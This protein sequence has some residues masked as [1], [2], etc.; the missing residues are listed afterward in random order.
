ML[1]VSP[2]SQPSKKELA[3]Q[4]YAKFHSLD[5]PTLIKTFQQEL[6]V[7]ENCARTYIS[8]AAKELNPTLNKPFRTRKPRVD[9]LK[10]VRAM[11]L[12]SANPALTRPEMIKLFTETLGMTKDS[13]ATHCSMCAKKYR[14]PKHAAI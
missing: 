7:T 11:E 3:K 6:A 5:R 9:N 14:G 2:T 10:Y 13:A 1:S 12:F 4:L 8:M